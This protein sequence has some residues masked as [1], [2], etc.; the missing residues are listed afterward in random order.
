MGMSL[1]GGRGAPQLQICWGS[2]VGACSTSKSPLLFFLTLLGNPSK[3]P[4]G[5]VGRSNLP[6]DL[7]VSEMTCVSQAILYMPGSRS[8]VL[9][10]SGKLQASCIEPCV[11]HS[12]PKPTSLGGSQLQGFL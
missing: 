4:G 10:S 3:F 8:P 1:L 5:E 9:E 12:T 2:L 7:G 6:L 11:L